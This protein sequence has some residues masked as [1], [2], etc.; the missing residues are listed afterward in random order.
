M[1]RVSDLVRRAISALPFAIRSPLCDVIAVIVYWPI[2]RILKGL[3]RLSVNVD[4][5]PLS[6]YRN[7]SLYSMRTDA[8]DRFGMQVEK[9]FTREQIRSMMEAAG[10][11]RISFSETPHWCAVGYRQKPI[12]SK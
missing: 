2:T 11:E 3:E 6:A 1:W 7:R 10:L 4:H 5:M 12:E 9:R 8:L